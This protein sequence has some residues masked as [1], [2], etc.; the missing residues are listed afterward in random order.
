MIDPRKKL[1]VTLSLSYIVLCVVYSLRPSFHAS[2]I[3]FD[4]KP[5]DS[6]AANA[7]YSYVLTFL[8]PPPIPPTFDV[9]LASKYRCCK[10]AGKAL[11]LL[12]FSP[13]PPP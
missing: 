7:N 6:L 13:L 8:L 12:I 5:L 2:L 4:N 9:H 1:P 10:E 3:S 11:L